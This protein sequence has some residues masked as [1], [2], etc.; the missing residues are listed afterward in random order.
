LDGVVGAV[1][2][3]KV[4]GKENPNGMDYTQ[5]IASGVLS[6]LTLGLVDHQTMYNLTNG[7]AEWLADEVFS[8]AGEMNRMQEIADARSCTT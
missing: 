6:G 5:S 2:A 8:N 7:A 4:T 3:D 1:N